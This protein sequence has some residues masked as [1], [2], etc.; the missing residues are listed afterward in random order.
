MAV[1]LRMSRTLTSAR[2][3]LEVDWSAV[4]MVGSTVACSRA[5]LCPACAAFP[6]ALARP[7]VSSGCRGSKQC[8]KGHWMPRGSTGVRREVE[9][10]RNGAV[11]RGKKRFSPPSSRLLGQG[12]MQGLEEDQM[13]L[14][15]KV[16]IMEICGNVQN[17]HFKFLP[18][19]V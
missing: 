2:G 11:Q 7:L 1:M 8:G 15:E 3:R 14:W 12:K 10:E 4:S 13:R 6:R 16:E 19:G 18:E 9:R 5:R 17:M